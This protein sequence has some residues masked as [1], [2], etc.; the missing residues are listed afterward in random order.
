MRRTHRHRI[1][2]GQEI[3]RKWLG[4]ILWSLPKFSINYNLFFN[5]DAGTYSPGDLL[6]HSKLLDKN[7][8]DF[9]PVKLDTDPTVND[10]T[11][12]HELL[13]K[14]YINLVVESKFFD[15]DTL[16]FSEKIFKPI[17]YL[18]P[19]LLVGKNG[20]LKLLRELGYKT[21]HP[22]IDESYDTIE[23]DNLRLNAIFSE[24]DRI[25]SLT[26]EEMQD[27]MVK[28]LPIVLHNYGII[29][30]SVREYMRE[31]QLCTELTKWLYHRSDG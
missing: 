8:Y 10:L 22:Y 24:I 28:C 17:R 12:R 31:A 26:H 14:A 20:S 29:Q 1:L 4:K 23:D 3:Y 15:H 13:D 27:M 5:P 25:C 2:L 18:Q 19:F 21:F 11:I 30:T 6:L 9:L 16:F 7:F